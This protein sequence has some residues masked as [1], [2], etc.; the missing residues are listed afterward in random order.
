MGAKSRR[1]GAQ[2][3]REL[4]Q[5]ARD[6]GFKDAKREAPMQ[7]GHGSDYPDVGQIHGLYVEGKRYK[8]TPVNKFARDLLDLPPRADGLLPV[9][10]WRDDGITKWRATLDGDV[11]LK[12]WNEMLEL[13]RAVHL[14]SQQSGKRA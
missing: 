9:L 13:R 14:V 3:E 8:R 5:L 10:M 12:M 6:C 11:F 7:A 2:G 1:K 4:A